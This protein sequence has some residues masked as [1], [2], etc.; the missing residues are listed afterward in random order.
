MEQIPNFDFWRKIGNL[1]AV[2]YCHC[3]DLVEVCAR[4][5]WWDR[6]DVIWCV[7]VQKRHLL[8]STRCVCVFVCLSVHPSVSVCPSVCL[9]LS[10][11]LSVSEAKKLSK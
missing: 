1:A 6:M 8:P 4:N 5:L 2:S 3:V 9:C 11:C 7:D 10:V